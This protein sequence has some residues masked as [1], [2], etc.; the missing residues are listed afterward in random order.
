MPCE[1]E[2][3]KMEAINTLAIAEF[4]GEVCKTR[5]IAMH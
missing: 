3:G 1:K 4:G 2:E 5:R